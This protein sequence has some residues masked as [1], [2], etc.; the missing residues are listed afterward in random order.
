MVFLN[1]HHIQRS[2]TN[3]LSFLGGRFLLQVTTTKHIAT[4]KNNTISQTDTKFS[5]FSLF[6]LFFLFY[7]SLISSDPIFRTRAMKQKTP[8]PS[9][10]SPPPRPPTTTITTTIAAATAKG[11]TKSQNNS[12]TASRLRASYKAKETPKTPPEAVNAVLPISSSTRA[13]SVTPDIK[14]NSRVKRGIVMNKAK[15]NEEIVRG[16]KGREVEEAKVVARFVRYHAVEQFAR[17][18]REVVDFGLRRDEEDIDGK[19]KKELQEKLEV[20]DSL[21]KNLESEVVALKSELA[22]MKSLNV[23][24]ESQNKKLTEDLAAAEAKVVTVGGSEKVRNLMLTS[25]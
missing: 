12:S 21:I 22:E 2:H 25:L 16:Q 7:H 15:P 3:L 23:E 14:N 10:P 19:K 17:P 5:A 24:L 4:H 11:V 13:K 1:C 9:P 18:R 20:S 8:P 6:F